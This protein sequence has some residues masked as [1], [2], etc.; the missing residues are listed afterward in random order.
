MFD[1]T[2]L[3]GLCRQAAGDDPSMVSDEE[4][5]ASVLEWQSVRSAV[6]VAEARL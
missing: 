5:L 3:S 2:E 4:L 6:D 1:M